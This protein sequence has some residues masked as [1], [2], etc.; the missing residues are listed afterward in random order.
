MKKFNVGLSLALFSILLTVIAFS[1]CSRAPEKMLQQAAAAAEAAEPAEAA[2][3][4]EGDTKELAAGIYQ[5]FGDFGSSLIV[6][7][8]QDVLITDPQNDGRAQKLA[9]VI[10]SLTDN[11]VT[12]IVLTHEHYDH[13]GGT[14][15][16]PDATVYGHVNCLPVFALSDLI[17]VPE[18]DKTFTDFESIPVGDTMVELH[19]LGPG[20]GEATTITYLPNEKIV[21]TADMYEDKQLTHKNWV[22]D[23]NFT[24]VRHILNTVSEWDLVHAVNA[25]SISTDPQ[26]LF[27][28]AQYYN[29]LYDATFAAINEAIAQQGFFAVF[30]LVDTLPTTLELDQYASWDN[31]DTSFPRHVERMLL[32]IFHGD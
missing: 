18:L 25:H 9:A 21:V 16:F 2:E 14:G 5:W 11:P 28:N 13:I 19:H 24:G 17:D 7:S 6:I 22:D 12:D 31:Y 30:G 4:L 1:G 27:D 15:I 29:D 23:K 20:D 10:A 3:A 32:S 8:G 26:V